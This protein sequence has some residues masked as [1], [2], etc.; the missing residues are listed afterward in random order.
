L[1]PGGIFFKNHLNLIYNFVWLEAAK[2]SFD[3]STALNDFFF[4]DDRLKMKA[5]LYTK[6]NISRFYLSPYVEFIIEDRKIILRNDLFNQV[7]IT[8]PL[9]TSP[10]TF[11]DRLREGID[12]NMILIF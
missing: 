10:E 9:K 1:G 5:R 11:I 3:G 2:S 12:E 4:N 7:I 8:P 6:E